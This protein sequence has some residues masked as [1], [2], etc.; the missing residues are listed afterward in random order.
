[1]RR[2]GTECQEQLRSR[3]GCRWDRRRGCGSRCLFA[4]RTERYWPIRLGP[5]SLPWTGLAVR[6]PACHRDRGRGQLRGEPG[7]VAKPRR[8]SAT[9][10]L[11]DQRHAQQLDNI[12]CCGRQSDPSGAL[13]AMGAPSR[14][15]GE[16]PGPE[17]TLNRSS[18]AKGNALRGKHP[19]PVLAGRRAAAPWARQG[20]HL[21]RRAFQ[22][23][24]VAPE[25]TIGSGSPER[26]VGRFSKRADQVAAICGVERAVEEG[27]V[28][29]VEADE[30]AVGREP[31]ITV[32]GLEDGMDSVLGQ[33]IVCLPELL[34]ILPKRLGGIRAR[35]AA[36]AASK[37]R[38]QQ[39]GGEGAAGVS[40][41]HE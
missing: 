31:E 4:Q 22:G 16:Y 19:E 2:I 41:H 33:P 1:M 8:S 10:Q 26:S 37:I 18:G 25:E 21:G 14:P 9:G 23:A 30:T 17:T 12:A 7:A 32:A 6:V 27:E 5:D 3:N 20:V 11:W 36:P 29:A 13:A 35:A 40:T 28:H 39:R 24:P 15:V 38:R 34:A